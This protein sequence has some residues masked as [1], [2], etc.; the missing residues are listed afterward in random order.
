MNHSPESDISTLYTSKYMALVNVGDRQTDKK[1]TFSINLDED[2][3]SIQKLV[4]YEY[5]YSS[6]ALIIQF[7]VS[8]LVTH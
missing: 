4:H 8:P 2:S 6:V 5:M 3:E 7:S 1:N